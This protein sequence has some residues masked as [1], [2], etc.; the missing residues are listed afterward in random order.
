[1]AFLSGTISGV[2]L[3]YLKSLYAVYVIVKIET[4]EAEELLTVTELEPS[5]EI[6]HYAIDGIGSNFEL[7]NN[8]VEEP[9][10][11]KQVLYYARFD[12][13][14]ETRLSRITEETIRFYA[15][16]L[17]PLHKIK[18]RHTTNVIKQIA[19]RHLMLIP[20]RGVCSTIGSGH[21]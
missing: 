15:N 3:F 6:N 7:V 5:G 4:R 20:W 14:S 1:M 19:S 18:S 9:S 16:H 21:T 13:S 2:T 12:P 11:A 17:S 8:I 10:G